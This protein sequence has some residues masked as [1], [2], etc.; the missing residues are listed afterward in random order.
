[1]MK[2]TVWDEMHS[3][4]IKVHK[5]SLVMNTCTYMYKVLIYKLSFRWICEED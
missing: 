4:F 5:Y 3:S 1:M 2:S